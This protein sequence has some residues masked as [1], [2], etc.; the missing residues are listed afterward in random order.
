[1]AAESR[2]NGLGVPAVAEEPRGG[3]GGQ[4][5]SCK[6][7]LKPG[8]IEPR[9]SWR[10]GGR[11]VEEP[12]PLPALLMAAPGQAAPLEMPDHHSVMPGGLGAQVLGG[13]RARDSGHPHHPVA[14]WIHLP[15]LVS[16]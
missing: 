8:L 14:V 2:G 15:G 16:F 6:A 10:G 13:W 11:S 3:L 5:A 7:A 4:S 12:H 1:M 9:L